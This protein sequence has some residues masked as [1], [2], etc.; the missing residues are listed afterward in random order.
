MLNRFFVTGYTGKDLKKTIQGEKSYMYFNIGSKRDYKNT[1]G[2]YDTDWI[3][4]VAYDALADLLDGVEK[5]TLLTI[6]GRITSFDKVENGKAKQYQALVAR[7]V[8]F[9]SPKTNNLQKGAHE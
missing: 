8:D 9:L 6:E 3:S 5:G 2:Q 7:K 1:E 4:F